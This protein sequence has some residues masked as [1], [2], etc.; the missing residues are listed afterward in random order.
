MKD[1]SAL[2]DGE[3]EDGEAQAVIA[4][5]KGREDLRAA[6]ATFHTI[7]DILRDDYLLSADFNEKFS[8]RLAEEPVVLAPKRRLS[9]RIRVYG[10]PVAA[11]AAAVAAV[12]WLTL[13]Q[14]PFNPVVEPTQSQNIALDSSN[15]VSRMPA[16]M[17]DY[18]WLHEENSPVMVRSVPYVHMLP[19]AMESAPAEG[20][21]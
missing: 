13:F 15:M 19:T 11:S 8:Q 12:G 1:V 6:W 14:N 7:G 5:L 9:E 18:L 16:A 21:R 17:N 3:L 20:G 10:L 2:M 4:R